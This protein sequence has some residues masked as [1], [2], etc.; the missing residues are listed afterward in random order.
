[1]IPCSLTNPGRKK[2]G[3]CTPGNTAR[4][5][6]SL[7]F[8]SGSWFSKE[9]LRTSSWF[10]VETGDGRD[11]NPPTEEA[12]TNLHPLNDPG[13]QGTLHRLL[14]INLY[15]ISQ[16]ENVFA[17]AKESFPP[18][19]DIVKHITSDQFVSAQVLL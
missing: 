4:V 11:S 3:S 16:G 13:K 1:M 9:N 2:R 10:L 14:R 6:A 5:N 19:G 15:I 7:V 17:S 8:H 18:R 12:G